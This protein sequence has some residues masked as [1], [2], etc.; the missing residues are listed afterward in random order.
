MK[1]FP[2]SDGR[3]TVY[4]DFA[5]V[6]QR[7]AIE[8]DGWESHAGRVRWEYDRERDAMLLR[9]GWRVVHVTSWSMERLTE[10]AAFIAAMVAR[11]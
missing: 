10:L 9:Q 7:V 8:A 4:V 11:A 5:Y 1:Q 6:E 3:R 2:V